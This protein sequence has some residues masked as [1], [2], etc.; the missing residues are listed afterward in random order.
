QGPEQAHRVPRPSR[1]PG[2]PVCPH[3]DLDLRSTRRRRL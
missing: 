2:G 3:D 1:G